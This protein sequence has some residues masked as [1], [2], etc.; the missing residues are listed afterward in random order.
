MIHFGG[1]Y[2]PEQWPEETWLKDVALM[3]EA[4][5]NIVSVGIFSWALLEPREGVYEFDWLDRVIEL[6]WSNGISIDLATPSAAPPA[7]SS[8]RLRGRA[9]VAT[10]T[11]SGASAST[12][13]A[14]TVRPVTIR[15]PARS[16][17][18]ARFGGRILI[19]TLRLSLL[20]RPR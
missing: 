18:P 13:S 15:A 19:A 12:S 4:G 1:D 14:S 2:N 8:G 6:L 16:A 3:R 20:S 9:P 7:T 5:V 17:S 10:I 11:T